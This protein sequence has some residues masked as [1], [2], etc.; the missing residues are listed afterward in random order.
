MKEKTYKVIVRWGR[1]ENEHTIIENVNSHA[2]TETVFAATSRDETGK[3]K[4]KITH[5]FGLRTLIFAKI[6]IEEEEDGDK[7]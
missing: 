4:Q 6:A 7:R 1:K 5:I 2:V 3:K